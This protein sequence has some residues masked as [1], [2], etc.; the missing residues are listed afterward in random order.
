MSSSFRAF[1]P[2]YE[3]LANRMARLQQV[4]SPHVTGP[5]RCSSAPKMAAYPISPPMT[6][7]TP[8]PPRRQAPPTTTPTQPGR[9]TKNTGLRK[10]NQRQLKTVMSTTLNQ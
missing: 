1:S 2:S 10:Y 5:S 9:V 7:Y 4:P 6:L 3:R 8:P